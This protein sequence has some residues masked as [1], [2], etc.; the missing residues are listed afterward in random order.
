M[1]QLME[2]RG[3]S[4]GWFVDVEKYPVPPDQMRPPEP[5]TQMKRRLSFIP[6]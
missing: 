6:Q 1:G 4:F 2:K 3:H 5:E